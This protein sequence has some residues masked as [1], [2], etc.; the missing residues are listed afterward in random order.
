MMTKKKMNEEASMSPDRL[1]FEFLNLD[2]G[3]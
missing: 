1:Q 2:F 3:C